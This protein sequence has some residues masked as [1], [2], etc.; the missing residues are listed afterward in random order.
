MIQTTMTRRRKSMAGR[1]KGWKDIRS[2][3]RA[4]GEEDRIV[5]SSYYLPQK[6]HEQLREEA[7][8]KKEHLSVVL[9]R[10]LKEYFHAKGSD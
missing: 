3:F 6:M 2:V 7:E 10:I 1:K 4:E 9:Y 8:R 5:R